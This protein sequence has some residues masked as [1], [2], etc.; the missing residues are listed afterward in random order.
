[1]SRLNVNELDDALVVDACPGFG[2]GQRS[3]GPP[4]QLQPTEAVRLLNVDI[5]DGTAVTRRGTEALGTVLPGPVQGLHWYDTPAAE[6]LVAVAAGKLWRWDGTAW[7][8]LAPY[9]SANAA[10][11]WAMAQLVDTLFLADG[12]NA[13]RAWDGA[14]LADLGTGSSTQAPV[15]TLLISAQNRLW[16]AGVAEVPDGLWASRFVDGATWDATT[17]MIRIGGGE[18][19]PITALAEW[20]DYQVAVFKRNSIYLVRAEPNATHGAD[21]AHSLANATV[22]K[23][24]DTI[25]CVAAR[26]LMRVGNDLWFLSDAGVFSLGR[27]LA[28]TQRELKQAVSGPVQDVLER[29][30]WA[31]A[32][33]AAAFFWNNY[34]LLS[35]P[36]EQATAPNT[37]L[38]FHTGRQAWA[39]E[40]QGWQPLSWALTRAEGAERL[41]FGQPDGTVWRWLDYVP[42]EH[43]V[44]LTY[45]DA[46][47]AIRT[48]VLTR[49]MLFQEALG[50]KNAVSVQTEFF[51]SRATAQVAVT[52]DEEAPLLLEP[53]VATAT[54]ELRLNFA[55]PAQL[56]TN[57]LRRRAFGGQHLPAF[58]TLQ[59]AVRAEAGK[60]ALRGLIGAAFVNTVRLEE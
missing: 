37:V 40:W 26:S 58:R 21:V 44:E 25:G 32:H 50:T 27:V 31:E 41:V 53:E 19:D 54:G 17:L 18:G 9:T 13:L 46:G 47:R 7:G 5:R 2:G 33:Q 24:S 20:D 23:I 8:T 34:Y 55:L 15:G 4:D 59:V 36:V 6:Y 48:E 14:A 30:H 45:Q 52:L 49:A 12:V 56:P 51:A 60:L 38:A 43:E 28:Q 29:V 57:G 35:L 11:P 1:M 3:Y 10:R 16:M 39:G 42:A 22:T